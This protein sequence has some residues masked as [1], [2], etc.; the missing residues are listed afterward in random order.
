[1]LIFVVVAKLGQLDW[2]AKTL[3]QSEDIG[4]KVHIIGRN[5]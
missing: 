5:G 3:Q 4:E 2:L 1:L